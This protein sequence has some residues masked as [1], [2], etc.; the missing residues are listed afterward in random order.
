MKNV[1]FV[2]ALSALF[3]SG[4]CKDRDRAPDPTKT[5]PTSVSRRLQLPTVLPTAAPLPTAEPV[6]E[7]P[8]PVSTLMTPQ[9]LP[10]LGSFAFSTVS[11]RYME[12][13]PQGKW[14]TFVGLPK[15]TNCPSF[16]GYT[17]RRDLVLGQPAKAMQDAYGFSA[18]RCTVLEW[19]MS[20]TGAK[21]T[22]VRDGFALTPE[23]VKSLPEAFATQWGSAQAQQ[24]VPRQGDRFVWSAHYPKLVAK[25]ESATRVLVVEDRDSQARVTFWALA[26]VNGDGIED[27]LFYVVNMA[28]EHAGILHR[29][30]AISRDLPSK[31]WRVVRVYPEN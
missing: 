16:L 10:E 5:T 6:Q 23:L 27:A 30:I 14:P 4:A 1:A 26:D 29:I 15:A 17:K 11:E 8:T 21:R 19:L 22:F 9:I 13:V 7:A 25:A 3:G 28:R 31:P 20:T 18:S 24:L 2:V 12:D